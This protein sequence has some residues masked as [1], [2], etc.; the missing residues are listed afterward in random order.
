[1]D[2]DVS[3]FDLGS[4]VTVLDLSEHEWVYVLTLRWQ[5]DGVL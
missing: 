5:P 2:S 1:M 3:L 4:S